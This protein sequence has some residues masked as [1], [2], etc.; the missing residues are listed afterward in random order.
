MS[1]S[2]SRHSA[3][4]VNSPT[5]GVVFQNQQFFIKRDDLLHPLFNGNKARKFL[6]HLD[7]PES[8]IQSV[9]SFGGNQSN[10][11]LALSA[12][13]KMKGWHFDYY[14]KK[15]PQQLKAFP[16]GNFKSAYDNGMQY[17]EVT[18][19]PV[20]NSTPNRLVIQQGGANPQAEY[21][22]RLLA[23]EINQWVEK[24]N[25]QDCCIFL[26][27]G[28]GTTAFYLQQHTV[29]PVYTTPC[30]GNT[31]YLQKQ[32]QSLQ[33]K[34]SNYP[35]IIPKQNQTR[36]GQPNLHHL[37]LW[38]QLLD[39]TG[40]EFDLL[41]D[42]TGWETLL[43]KRYLLPTNII[44]IHCGGISGNSS[45]LSRYKHLYNDSRPGVEYVAD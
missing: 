1:A 12:L 19:F 23:T 36:F 37:K 8:Q 29:F 10:A 44:Y 28:T 5:V 25:I 15:L 22:I 30:I 40:I 35:S 14:L 33:T 45:M 7:L 32:W 9:V 26:P 6:Y 11:M 31:E 39:Q 3:F 34:P 16:T 27:S 42:P 13:A 41:Y 21:G 17:H 38:K 43:Q 2:Q 18:N 20:L 4:C 24:Q